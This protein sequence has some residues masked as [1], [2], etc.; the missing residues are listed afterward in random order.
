MNGRLDEPGAR[1]SAA[2]KLAKPPV[3]V[4]RQQL[5]DDIALQ[6]SG[7]QESARTLIGPLRTID[8]FRQGARQRRQWLYPAAPILALLTWR[9]RPRLASLPGL[10]ARAFAV[11]RIVK[12][13]R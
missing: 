12:H 8:R 10:A 13:F 1:Q 3:S 5:L 6:R 9:L 2:H 4:R 11:W 7:L